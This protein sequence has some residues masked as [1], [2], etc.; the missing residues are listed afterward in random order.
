LIFSPKTESPGE[1][2]KAAELPSGSLYLGSM[3]RRPEE[4]GSSG[5]GMN[6]GF[7]NGLTL[8]SFEPFL[9]FFVISLSPS[10]VIYSLERCSVCCM[11]AA[12][13]KRR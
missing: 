10:L 8:P 11:C 5:P 7:F 1:K 4:P 6:Y 9:T 12:K 2:I 13:A 3:V